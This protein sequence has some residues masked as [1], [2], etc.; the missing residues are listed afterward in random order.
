MSALSRVWYA[1]VCRTKRARFFSLMSREKKKVQN[2]E[3]LGKHA[4]PVVP[5]ECDSPLR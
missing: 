1:T 2:G 5:M 3:T 4:L